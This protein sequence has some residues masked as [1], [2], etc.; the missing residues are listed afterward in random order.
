M[1]P[2]VGGAPIFVIDEGAGVPTLFLHGNPDSAELW[3][4]PIARLRDR[5]RCLAPDLPGFGRSGVPAGFDGSL[6]AMARFVDDL[7]AALGIGGPLNI[8][9]HD[10]GGRFAL[11]WAI[12][13]PE[14]ARRVVVANTSFSA[15]YRW[16]RAARLLRLPLVGE[17]LMAATNG[18]TLDRTLRK[19]APRLPPGH[20]QRAGELYGRGAKRMALRLYRAGGPDSFRG[21]EERLPALAARVPTC[22][23]WGDRDPYAP[24]GTAESFGAREI[25]HFPECGHWVVIEA[26]AEVAAILGEFLR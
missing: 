10:F 5:H 22:V 15:A 9:G 1:T 8:V 19:D 25:Y 14:K 24:V 4:G 6:A 13:H 12:A 3:R 18:A 20:F 7:V 16:H 21:W 11:A 23:L 26:E 2:T 17:L